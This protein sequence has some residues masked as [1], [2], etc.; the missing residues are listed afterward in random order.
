[1][2]RRRIGNL[3]VCAALT[4]TFLGCTARQSKPVF[5]LGAESLVTDFR[6]DEPLTAKAY[7]NLFLYF[8]QGFEAYHTATGS[9]A[10]FPG[11]PSRNGRIA[12]GM[13][14]FSR[15]APVWGVWVSSGRP[16]VL[17]LPSGE[18]VDLN[19]TFKRGLLS[20][21]DPSSLGFW[22]NISDFDQRI[23]EASDVA[24]SLW[25]FRSTVWEQL[26]PAE[27][28]QV[29]RWLFEVNGKRLPDNNWHLF[30]TFINAVLEKLGCPAD[31]ALALEHY[32]RFKQFYR[33]DG[34]FSDGPGNIF[35]YYNAW[36]IHYQLYWLSQVAPEW[37]TDF[38]SSARRQFAASY[39]YLV[40]FTGVPI[41]G[42]SVCYRMGAV[43]PLIF[44][45]SNDGVSPGLARR[46]LDLTWK[47]FIRNGAVQS[48]NVTQGYCGPDARILD[49]YSGPA[50]CLWALRSLVVA[51]YATP[52]SSFWQRS[53][54]SLPVEKGDFSFLIK[55]TGWTVHG[56]K[57][58]GTIEIDIPTKDSVGTSLEPYGLWRRIA[59]A[60]LWRPFRPNN[61]AAKYQRPRYTS[62]EPFCE[63]MQ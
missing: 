44:A 20:G 49:N 50:S 42:R 55:A 35:D 47:Y 18:S 6:S 24:L 56:K 62:N 31:H 38:I 60:V 58:T 27:K 22:G 21:T 37:D 28:T 29:A 46:A 7:D 41:L 10:V 30:V 43:A 1:M 15:M 5:P 45:S 39:Q 32:E 19:A 36:G 57:Q 14:G 13:E 40:G 33:G 48:G 3:V 26:S 9:M 11:L 34:W 4:A 8:V 23:V 53:E 54:E 12:D 16:P 51:F 17:K 2:S 25:L 52:Q 63:C 59:S 61:T